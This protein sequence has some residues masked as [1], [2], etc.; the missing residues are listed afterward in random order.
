MCEVSAG[1]RPS[2]LAIFSE[3]FRKAGFV[4]SSN[5]RTRC[6]ALPRRTPLCAVQMFS[7][8]HWHSISSTEAIKR[9]GFS[10]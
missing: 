3:S 4:A 6:L 8:S 10:A 9:M 7:M 2:P 5:S 1:S